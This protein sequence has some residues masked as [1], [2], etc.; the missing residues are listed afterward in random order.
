MSTY[1]IYITTSTEAEA[2][3]IGK[4]LLEGKLVACVNIL[5][6]AKSFYWW[7]G[8][9][10]EGSEAVLIAKTTGRMVEKVKEKVCELHSY[11]CPCV[12][13]LNIDGGNDNFLDWIE[14]SVE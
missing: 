10:E 11:E 1:L 14:S 8:K 9:I 7:E 4:K 3:E 12:V 5:P 13:A 6:S 2:I